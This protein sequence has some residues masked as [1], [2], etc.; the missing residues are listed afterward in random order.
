M[1]FPEHSTFTHREKARNS[2]Y[3]YEEQV[4]LTKTEGHIMKYTRVAPIFL[5]AAFFLILPRGAAAQDRAWRDCTRRAAVSAGVSDS[6]I[7]IT[8]ETDDRRSN[9]Y[10][11]SWE[12][13]SNDPRRQRGYCEISRDDRRIVRFETNPY[14]G[15]GGGP[16]GDYDEPQVYTGPYAH[17]KVDTDGTGYF[18]SRRFKS[19]RLER[20]YVDTREQPSVSLRGR[21]G[22]RVTFYGEV[23]SSDGDRELTLR[24]TS[25]DR[26]DARGRASIRLNGDHNEVEWISLNGRMADGGELKAEFNRNRH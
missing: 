18:S 8:A 10:I 6:S 19:D 13:R 1:S 24:I 26:G 9:T 16:R 15:G 7:Q 25:S 11:L 20:G 2:D 23:I 14:R 17:V 22:F 12:V 5:L 3:D 21:N 4:R